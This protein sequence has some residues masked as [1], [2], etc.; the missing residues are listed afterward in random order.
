MND[1]FAGNFN[2]TINTKIHAVIKIDSILVTAPK[3]FANRKLA[4][5]LTPIAI[6]EARIISKGLKGRSLK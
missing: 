1:K 3:N 5:Q 4:I 2:G 6:R